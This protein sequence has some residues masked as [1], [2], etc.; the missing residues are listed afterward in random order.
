MPNYKLTLYPNDTSGRFVSFLTESD[1]YE[2]SEMLANVLAKQMP[3]QPDSYKKDMPN[4]ECDW[5]GD[6]ELDD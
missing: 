6:V 5:S 1:S 2:A 4:P 3:E